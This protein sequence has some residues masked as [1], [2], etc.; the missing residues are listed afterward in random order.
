G[1]PSGGV[2]GPSVAQFNRETYQFSSSW[3]LQQ[4]ATRYQYLVLQSTQHSLV[5]I[6]H[7]LEPNLK[8]LVYQSLPH[9]N[10]SAPS[11]LPTATS[12]TDYRADLVAHGDWF[13]HDQSGQ[14]IYAAH[15]TNHFVMDV[16]NPG[17]QVQCAV[18]ATALAKQYGFDGVFWDVVMGRLDWAMSRGL[19]VPQYPTQASWVGAMTSALAYIAP[20]L[21]R[22]GLLSIGNLSGTP[23]VA[24]WQQWAGMLDGVEEESWTDGGL[25]AAQQVPYWRS[26][27]AELAW[28]QA[29]GKYEIVHSYSGTESANT[30]G[31]AAMLLAANG[32][33]SYSTSNTNYTS[34]E[35]W[36]PE[37]S[38]AQQLGAPAGPYV[39][40]RNGV[41]ERAFSNGIV[42]VNPS[43]VW[44][45]T[46]SL[47][48][49]L[50]S[51]SGLSNASAAS[52]P[53]TS[54]LI[55]LKTG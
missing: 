28:T 37:Y 29:N 53:P 30:Y 15:L 39:V 48:G 18:G 46:F 6:L 17:Y 38:L 10:A 2:P 33:A 23:N 45:P 16:G 54:G 1:P 41:Y 51:G 35:N 12:C 50:Y 25:G 20:A 49:G 52:L 22:Q 47:G 19:T 31:L 13:L 27:L 11:N 14:M 21:R 4:V 24:V 34:N 26:K 44:V 32:Y 3:P 8:I 55:L 40:L 43:A 42:L 5:P 36:F 9:T 7:A